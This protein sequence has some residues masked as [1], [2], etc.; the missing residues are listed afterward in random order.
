MSDN[1]YNSP[2]WRSLRDRVI[3]RDG[4]R[5]TVAR[6]LGG[7]CSDGLHVHH[8][9]PRSERSDLELEEDNCATTCPA[10]HP[11]WESLRRWLRA[12]RTVPPCNHRHPYPQGREECARR[13]AREMGLLEPKQLAV[14]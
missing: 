1:F 12:R 14:V 7:A 10:H 2:E 9:I 3:A 8:V 6:L 5:C 13:R 4:N 11:I